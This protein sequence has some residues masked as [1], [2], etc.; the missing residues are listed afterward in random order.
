MT[1]ALFISASSDGDQNLVHVVW[2]WR[3]N[4]N[5]NL[6]ILEAMSVSHWLSLVIVG[7][8]FET[9]DENRRRMKRFSARSGMGERV[10]PQLR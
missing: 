3:K 4:A 1:R 8:D 10:V 2:P 5:G 9:S 6:G 7:V